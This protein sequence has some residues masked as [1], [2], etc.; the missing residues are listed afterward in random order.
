MTAYRVQYISNYILLRLTEH[1]KKAIDENFVAGR[2]IM[3]LSKEFHSIPHDLL[4][5]KLHAYGFSKKTA[6]FIYSYSKKRKQNVK[7]DN[8]VS[9][10]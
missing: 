1:W 2:V 7:I 9:S 3:D 10:F 4:I 6:T 5:A 8:I